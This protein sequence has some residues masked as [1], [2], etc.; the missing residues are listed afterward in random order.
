MKLTDEQEDAL[1]QLKAFVQNRDRKSIA[2]SGAAG[3]GKTT[4]LE[5]LKPLL[6]KHQTTWAAMTGKAAL[7]MRE[8]AG[9]PAT[10]LHKV[11]YLRPDKDNQG[12]LV[13]TKLNPPEGDFLVIDECSMTGPGVY[14]DVQTWMYSGVRVIFVGDGYQLPPV[15]SKREIK[16]RGADF[17]VFREE[18]GPNLT[19]CMRSGDDLVAIANS[20]R[21]AEEIPDSRGPYVFKE[22]ESAHT[23]AVQ[24]YIADPNDHMLIT[25]TNALRMRTN[26]LVRKLQGHKGVLP[27]PGEPV[28]VCQN[29]KG[30]MNGEILTVKA[31][32]PGPS[33]GEV[34]SHWLE[35]EELEGAFLVNTQGNKSKMD[36]NRPYIKDWRTYQKCLEQSRVA[37]PIPITYGYVG[38]AHRCQGSQFRRVTAFLSEEDLDNRFFHQDTFLPNGEKMAFST[39]WLYTSMTRAC[40]MLTLYL[41]PS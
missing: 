25:W 26:K 35:T 23:E 20:V 6:N 37:E 4:L 1:R 13:F 22:I 32:A 2:L 27:N 12:N 33:F 28:F 8:V 10:T 7:R 24:D 5:H 18:D 36:G 11:L 40:E 38:T 41:E 9:V 14:D 15:L 34:S 3:T 29:G 30:V 17:S 31:L 16:A 21:D 19:K 39:R